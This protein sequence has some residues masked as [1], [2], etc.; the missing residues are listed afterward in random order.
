MA[1]TFVLFLRPQDDLP[2]LR[3]LHLADLT[4][5][6]ALL[7]LLGG[8]LGRGL[9][10]TRTP[11]ELLLVFALAGVMLVTMPFSIWPGGA[12]EV[13]T[14]LFIKVVLIC[15]LMVST[16]TTQRRYDRFITLVVVGTTYVAV[17]SVFDYMRGLNLVEGDR[18]GGAVGGLFGNPNDMA[19]NM[20]TFL[21][22]AAALALNR[23]S[24]LVRTLGLVA[25][26]AIGL[27]IIFSKSRG[28]TV[29]LV[30]ML[31]VLLF[32]LRRTKPAAAAL[33]IAAALAAMPLLP[34]SFYDRMSSIVNADED[35]TGSR[36]ARKTL[37]REGYQAFLEY[38][39][40]GLGAGQF[41]NYQPEHREE[42]WRETHNAVLQVA[43]ELGIGGL[44]IFV[45]VIGS[46][47]MAAVR[48]SRAIRHAR[49]HRHRARA[50]GE[51]RGLEPLEVRGAALIAGL[52]GWFA[53]AMFASLAY[54]WTFYLILALAS[55]FRDIGLRAAALEP[56]D[57]RAGVSAPGRA[58]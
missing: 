11:P 29:G 6:F 8:R 50:P 48:T 26:P 49:T 47:F 52:T 33:V 12:L 31:A 45:L 23:G 15:A 9:G 20:V 4:A 24:T 46:G 55:V 32:H 56:D 58:A 53:A 54:Y 17:R 40:F 36:E 19:L 28:G 44:V 39:V 7:A 38:P 51:A 10:P 41:Q 37:L 3:A 16:I 2:F 42:A 18:I 5:G 25:M 22:F 14:D 30:A 13:F 27:A 57:R 1:F 43:A 21:P 34:G 35:P